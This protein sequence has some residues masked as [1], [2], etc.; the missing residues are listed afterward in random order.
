MINPNFTVTQEHIDAL[1]EFAAKNGEKWKWNLGI[2]WMNGS[3][4]NAIKDGHLLRQVRNNLG[5]KWLDRVNLE[6]L[7]AGER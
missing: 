6:E 7:T 5:P 3:D 1:R 4:V 2:A